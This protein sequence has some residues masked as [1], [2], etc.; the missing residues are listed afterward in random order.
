MS[1]TQNRNKDERERKK[2]GREKENEKREGNL[3]DITISI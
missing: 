1:D 3:G 2:G